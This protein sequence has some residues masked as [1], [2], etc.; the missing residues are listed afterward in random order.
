MT[1]LET[2][3]WQ[4]L[5]QPEKKPVVRKRSKF[6]VMS[7]E[8]PSPAMAKAEKSLSLQAAAC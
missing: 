1:L 6:L 4:E 3:S 2:L 8:F 7:T 5:N